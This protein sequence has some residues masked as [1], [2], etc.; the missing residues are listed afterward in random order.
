MK[1]VERGQ[2]V[3]IVDPSGSGESII[4]AILERFHKIHTGD[5]KV[6]GHPILSADLGLSRSMISLAS[7]ETVL[8]WGTIKENIL[9]EL[10]ENTHLSHDNIVRACPDADI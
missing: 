10:E 9:L 3:A 6:N 1:P 5:V 2:I 4:T 7:Q 8:Y